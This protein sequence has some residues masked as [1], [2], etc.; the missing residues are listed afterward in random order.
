MGSLRLAHCFYIDGVALHG[1][2][3]WKYAGLWLVGFIGVGFAEEFT[4]RGYLQYTFASGIGFW[5]AAVLTS[6]LFTL[7]HMKNPGETFLG[8]TD[9]FLFGMLACFM[10]WRTGD[11]W[12]AV[13]FH[14]L[15]DW[16]LSFFYSVADSGIPALGH[17]FNSRVQG[18][19]WLSGGTAGPEGS[20]INLFF[21]LLYFVIIAAAFPQREFVGWK[22]RQLRSAPVAVPTRESTISA[23]TG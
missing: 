12:L 1:I 2:E 22:S 19:S 8:L 4:V 15:W 13:G 23:P 14:A 11:M 7:G 10:W 3:V 17:L 5:P 9:V 6:A 20:A 21:D 18:P 16:G